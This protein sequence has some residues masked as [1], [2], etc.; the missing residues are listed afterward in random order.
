M[1]KSLQCIAKLQDNDAPQTWLYIV[2]GVICVVLLAAVMIIVIL[3]IRIRW[4]YLSF[5]ITLV[6]LYNLLYSA[7]SAGVGLYEYENLETARIQGMHRPIYDIKTFSTCDQ[8]FTVYCEIAGQWCSSDVVIHFDRRY[9]RSS[10]GL[11]DSD[12]SSL[13][14][15]TVIISFISF[16][17]GGVI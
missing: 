16:Y 9:L 8:K 11:R 17:V 15:K 4:L 6:V 14:Q 7:L 13:H 5:H 2:I 10:A 12:C 3:C 1:I